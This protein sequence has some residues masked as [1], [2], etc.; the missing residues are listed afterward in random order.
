MKKYF[1]PILLI[2]FWSCEE[3]VEEDTTPPTVTITFPQNNTTVS[4][5]VSITCISSDNEG[6]EKV[7]LWVNGA[8]SG[9][10][11]DSEPYSINW[12]TSL[13]ENGNYTITIRSYDT[14]NNIADSEPIILIVDNAINEE[15][16]DTTPPT[17]SI[18]S[19]SS[20]QTV[21]GVVFIIAMTQDNEGI[22]KVEFFI[23]DSLVFSDAESPYEYDWNTIQ[24]ENNSEHIVKVISY[25]NSDNFTESQPILIIVNNENSNLWNINS[26]NLI[27]TIGFANDIVISEDKVFVAAG[28]SGLQIWDLQDYSLIDEYSGYEEDGNFI[29]YED[30]AL[31]GLS[32]SNNAL[33][34]SESNQD[35]K[36]FHYDQ[37]N[38]LTYRNTIMSKRTKDFIS[39]HSDN[40]QFVMYSADNDDG[41][42]WHYYNLDSTSIFGLDIIN[43]TPFGGSEIYTPGKPLGIDSDGES[44]IAMAVD[45]LGVEL[46]SID[47][48]GDDP[49]FIGRVDTDGNAENVL[50]DTD[51]IYVSS[52][53]AGGYFISYSCF[54][55]EICEKYNFARDYDVNHI[56]IFGE[57]ALLSLRDDGIAIY[58]IN[59]NA[60]PE[61]KGSFDI[62]YVYKT[63]IWDE[64]IIA[65]MQEGLLIFS[66]ENQ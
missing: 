45:Q 35:V 8:T 41:M 14:S 34:L 16:L 22:S 47:F 5:I 64:K 23:D 54:E 52:R 6:V 60:Q 59:D 56:S 3:E 49:V 4:E 55:S 7:E 13:L 46:F 11:D 44:V 36:V 25:D 40:D 33:F 53:N 30:L 62:G 57:I 1:L 10:I 61:F 27:N 43:W 51:G 38:N 37:T 32:P 17:V 19:H 15:E 58:K 24:Y 28:Q 18:S 29:E 31:I 26:E 50:L 63:E 39:F 2:G 21:N 66:I 48:L 42:K 65:C 9:S 20:G 12:N